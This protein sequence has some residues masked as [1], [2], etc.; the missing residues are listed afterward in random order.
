MAPTCTFVPD[1]DPMKN[2][3]QR[4]PDAKIAVKLGICP[5]V[6]CKPAANQ[7]QISCTQPDNYWWKS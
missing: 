7:L 1:E 3:R 2:R 5:T 6:G 4:S